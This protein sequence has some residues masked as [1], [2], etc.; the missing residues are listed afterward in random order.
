MP[1]HEICIGCKWNNYPICNGTVINDVNLRIDNLSP[2]FK[3]GVKDRDY[4][5]YINTSLEKSEVEL[6]QEQVVVIDDLLD[7]V[8]NIIENPPEIPR[9]DRIEAK[10]NEIIDWCISQGASIE[11]LP[12]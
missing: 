7:A 9:L 10:I 11:R 3:C 12:E 6:L 2:R 5:H 1:E 4:I 8:C